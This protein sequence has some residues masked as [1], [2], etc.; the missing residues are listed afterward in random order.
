MSRFL[1]I[2]NEAGAAEILIHGP[3]GKS[4]WS[5]E[6][7]SGEDF[8]N[9]LNKFPAGQKV[10]VG[11]NS[12]G[13][14]VA[15]GLAIYNAIDRRSDDI[16]ARVDGYA[17]SIASVFPLAASKVVSPKS[18]IWMIH[19]AHM[20]SNGNADQLRKDAEMLDTHDSVIAT[21]YAM[22]TGKSES[23]VES[24]MESETWMTGEEAVAWGLADEMTEDTPSLA[25]FDTTKFK[26]CP[27]NFRAVIACGN[28]KLAA[29]MAAKLSAPSQ[30]AASHQNNNDNMKKTI[31]A[32]LKK[33]GIEAADNESDEQLQAKLDR[34][35]KR[36]DPPTPPPTTPPT[37][38][39]DLASI[40]AAFLASERKRITAEVK[41]AAEG[42]IPNDKLG[43]W[44]D[45]A[46]KDEAKTLEQIESMSA[47][48][49]GGNPIGIVF[50]GVD[51]PM[52]EIR[53]EKNPAT[54]FK[55]VR[56][57]FK[58]LFDDA[59]ARDMRRSGR[60]EASN[61]YSATLVTNFLIDGAVTKLQ[62]KWAALRTF[63]R[64]YSTD[65]YKPLATGQLKFVSAGPS[66]QTD[67]TNFESGN[68]TVDPCSI[69]VHQYSSSINVSNSDL[70]SGLRMENLMEIG[71]SKLAD[72]IIEVATAPITTANFTTNAALTRS[73][74]SFNWSDMQTLWGQLKKSTTHNA[75]LDGEYLAQI[76]NVPTQFQKSGVV[77]GTQWAEFGWDNIALNTDWTGAGT[78]VR[79]FACNPQAIGAVAGLPLVPPTIPGQTLTETSAIVPGVEIAIGSYSWFS[80]ASRTMWMSY[81]IMFGAQ[82]LDETA[83]VIIKSA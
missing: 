80:L 70:N 51:N 40:Q 79:G 52:D 20:W 24:A 14:S 32:L 33:H 63:V 74:G 13:G 65:R 59:C 2:K 25:S 16:T 12:Q 11:I 9:A 31:I 68:S 8:T 54:R 82:L 77:P 3:I 66:V 5:D 64:D 61:T 50:A 81:D 34:I 42:K 75:L 29:A 41:R 62:N 58:A 21:A 43:W 46:V 27:T 67:A 7:V 36:E 47:Q 71:I 17:L 18:S 55:R 23:D 83:G 37:G 26:N 19:K 45:L 4:I 56:D 1:H 44:I 78:N 6:G 73:A 48:H 53:K 28:T 69:T 30:G 22:K 10:T 38:T 35:P 57:D 15:D 76:I 72:K 49:V 60:V 39:I